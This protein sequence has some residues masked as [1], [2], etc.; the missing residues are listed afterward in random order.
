MLLS[1]TAENQPGD[2]MKTFP[3]LI[4]ALPTSMKVS[5]RERME[6]ELTRETWQRQEN[7]RRR[8]EV[9]EMLPDLY[10]L[11]YVLNHQLN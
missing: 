8:G 11:L 10:C 6:Q 5:E 7:R 9:S 4:E 3:T 2:W 1:S